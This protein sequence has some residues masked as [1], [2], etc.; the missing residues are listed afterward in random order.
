LVPLHLDWLTGTVFLDAG[1][2]WGP[3][4]ELRGYYSPKRDA[5]VS[6]GFEVLVRALP[7]WFQEMDFR[8]GL[9]FPLSEK[10]PSGQ[11]DDVRGHL[12]LGM[13]F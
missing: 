12:R 3:E 2:A 10:D 4:L 6:A 8:A 13:S 11:Q 9:A 7:F 5:L 1:N